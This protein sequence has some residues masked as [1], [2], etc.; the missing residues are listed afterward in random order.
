LCLLVGL[1]IIPTLWAY[2]IAY[3]AFAV[4]EI[5]SRIKY[6]INFGEYDMHIGQIAPSDRS[7]CMILL[8]FKRIR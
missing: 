5:N 7:K 3:G 4:Y 8:A 1:I 6:Q 2:G